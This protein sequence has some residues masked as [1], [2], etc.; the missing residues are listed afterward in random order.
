MENKE[1]NEN[2]EFYVYVHIRLD[3]NTVFYV[4]KGTKN[5]AYNLSRGKGT[6]HDNICKACGCKVVIIKNNLTESQAFRLEN[7]MI[8]YYVHTLGYGIDIEGYDDYDHKL[9][10]LTNCTWG[11]EGT[12]GMH[13]TEEAKQ[14]ISE[15]N[16]GRKH[17]EEELQKMS[18]SNK[19]KKNPMYGKNPYAN[20][21][22]EEM[23]EIKQKMSESHKGI[24]FSEEHKQNISESH[25]GII[26]WNKGKEMSEEYKQKMKGENNGMWGKP[27][28]NRRKVICITTGK[29]FDSIT[30]ASNWYNV[31]RNTISFCCK[32]K[33]K[34]AGKLDGIPLEWKYEEDDDNE[35]KA[36]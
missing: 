21:T 36:V 24:Q 18:E 14:N 13:H 25:K 22:E 23:E 9:P 32:G 27:A 6:H 5:R 4:G 17:S 33:Q 15:K 2:R 20:K 11:G 29:K 8:K 3:N 26:P 7:K 31:A 28:A 35:S 1:N 19:G 34:H 12:S 30:E 10:H 16:K